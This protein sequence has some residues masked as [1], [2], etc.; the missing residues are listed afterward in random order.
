MI[1]KPKLYS[2][3]AAQF[4]EFVRNDYPKFIA[5]VEAY[6]KFLSEYEVAD[7]ETLRNLDTAYNSFLMYFRKELNDNTP[8]TAV[9]EKF[10]I[11]KAKQI[12]S[13]KGSEEA[14]K[15]LFR[16]LFNEQ[17]S[18][19][20]PSEQILRSSDGVW[21]QENFITTNQVFGSI[22]DNVEYIHINNNSGNFK[23]KINRVESITNSISRLYYDSYR[24]VIYEDNQEI[25]IYDEVN[26][27]EYVGKIIPSPAKISVIDG[28]EAWQKG[29]VIIIP[30]S[31]RNTIARITE[32]G[33][34]GSIRN[35]EILD[36]GYIHAENQ[37]IIVSPYPN[38]PLSSTVDY[39]SEVVSISPLVY[40]HTLNITDYTDGTTDTIVGVSDTVD[41][42]SYFLENFIERG[43]N[44]RIVISKSQ[45]IGYAP[46]TGQIFD[47]SLSDWFNSRA[48]LVLQNENV[49]KTKGYFNS[50][51]GQVSNQNIILEDNYY[52]QPYSYVI[53]T[54]QTIEKYDNIIPSIRPSG[55]IQF[56]NYLKNS[57]I[58]ID[59][60][61]SRTI[62]IEKIYEIDAANS[63]DSIA[64]NTTKPFSDATTNSQFVYKDF[65]KTLNDSS[66]SS[67]SIDKY[68]VKGISDLTS[69]S[70]NL[71]KD[72]MKSL[73]ASAESLENI[74]KQ[75]SK[76]LDDE[77]IILDSVSL[78]ANKYHTD[79]VSAEST[80]TSSYEYR[81]YNTEEYF[82]EPYTGNEHILTI[83]E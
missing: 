15:I 83:G 17:I 27:L 52:Y 11:S 24:R 35:I 38:K 49:V 53:D 36:H 80:D 41:N 77:S 23:L 72:I 34:N 54:E 4:P 82:S 29:Q 31:V 78:L 46:S 69:Q 33:E 1:T 75:V 39:I 65:I 21:S 64:K 6:Y 66:E 55:L 16:L 8:F 22:P 18:V 13:A 26:N 51:R 81:T 47:I 25:K 62:S 5:F 42:N 19:R 63:S 40:H 50:E 68:F 43:Y 73:F 70:D 74:E 28:G 57:E 9:N 20:Y 44:G 14:F 58:T 67:E 76:I 10:I 59:A 60:S 3:V 56:S 45:T 37:S 7:V 48:I 79:T 30:G 32:T 2:I 12:H 71:S 61:I